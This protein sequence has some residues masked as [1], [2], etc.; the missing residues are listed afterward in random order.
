MG[1]TNVK[2]IFWGNIIIHLCITNPIVHT[3]CMAPTEQ[4][5]AD[6]STNWY[7]I[8]HVLLPSWQ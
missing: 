6:S 8:N 1:S 4:C 7:A 3:G 5:F 2:M